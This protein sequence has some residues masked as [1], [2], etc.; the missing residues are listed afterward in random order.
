MTLKTQNERRVDENNTAVLED[1][2]PPACRKEMRKGELAAPHFAA[3][4]PAG[5][6]HASTALQGSVK[7][8]SISLEATVKLLLSNSTTP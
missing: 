2:F 5:E 6:Q 1:A 4:C 3:R 8:L 7:L